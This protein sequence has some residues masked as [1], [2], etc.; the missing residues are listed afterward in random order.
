MNL[1]KIG[2]WS[3]SLLFLVLIVL[4][5]SCAEEMPQQTFKEFLALHSY[6]VG[7]IQLEYKD[8]SRDRLLKTEVWY[9]TKDT[10][11]YNISKDYPF[12]LPPT[13]K[14]ARMEDGRFPLILLS[15]GTGGNRIS[16]MW[17]ACELAGKGYIVVAVDHFGNTLDN[18]IPE[19][20]VK[21]W[22][23]PMDISFILDKVLENRELIKS[24]DTTKIGVAGF[25]L[26]GYTTLA[27]A[28]GH[29]S[30]S[31]LQSFSRTKRGR[32]EF[33]TPEIGDVSNLIT[34]EIV[35]E[36]PKYNLELKD[37]R[38]KAFV[39]M[40]PAL[41]QGF[42]NMYSFFNIDKPV[43]IIGAEN[44]KIAPVH[45][46]ARYYHEMIQNATYI[47]LE[48]EVGHYVFMNEAK[49]GLKR[50]APRIFKDRESVNREK[51]HKEVG[52]IVVSF[53]RKSFE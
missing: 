45:T 37:E 12:H 51:I 6:N 48:G 26:G 13:S 43:L 24:I 11:G 8:H 17:L 49:S 20:F 30:Y 52:E 18:Q 32:R 38:I 7:Q 33:T 21:I 44:D 15:H 2:K 19:Y 40:A 1:A 9:P 35:K 42:E 31:K 22:H 16:Q 25:S 29:V 5:S 4:V 39:A 53:F 46:N 34:P 47:E 41:G 3:T 28:G 10:M 14:N 23:R 50:S 27:L 36:G